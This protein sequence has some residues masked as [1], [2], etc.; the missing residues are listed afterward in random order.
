MEIG[1]KEA[2][3]TISRLAF[4]L[5]IHQSSPK[6]S[7]VAEIEYCP[8]LVHCQRHPGKRALTSYVCVWC[9]VHIYS[10]KKLI[11]H[12]NNYNYVYNIQ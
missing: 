6:T 12:I 8:D 5:A 10:V 4:H 2:H 7:V 9:F 1:G 11:A 3:V